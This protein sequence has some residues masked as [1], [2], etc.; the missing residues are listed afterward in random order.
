MITYRCVYSVQI[1]YW[2][3]VIVNLTQSRVNWG[4]GTLIEEL[5]K[6]DWSVLQSVSECLE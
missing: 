3:A 1:A 4:E 6:S 5:P 2:L